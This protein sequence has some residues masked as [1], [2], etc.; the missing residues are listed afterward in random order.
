MRFFQISMPPTQ[1][2]FEVVAF[3]PFVPGVDEDD[4]FWEAIEGVAIGQ[5]GAEPF[6]VGLGSGTVQDRGAAVTTPGCVVPGRHDA[7]ETRVVDRGASKHGRH[8]FG[9]GE[10]T[11]VEEG[12]MLSQANLVEQFP[13]ARWLPRRGQRTPIGLEV[14]R[15]VV[16]IEL[17]AP[18]ALSGEA[19]H[20]HQIEAFEATE[21]GL[22]APEGGSGKGIR[23]CGGAVDQKQGF[24][25]DTD[26][27]RVVEKGQQ[28]L[29]VGEVVCL[30]VVLGDQH[31]LILAIPAACPVFIGPAEAEWKIWSA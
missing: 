8:Y 30:G 3:G 17:G 28:G 13:S 2:R 23:Q 26:V 14:E 29:D 6:A 24:V 10:H 19:L 4:G 5:N 22:L 27:A 21:L 16:A 7:G 15:G 18:L 1:I 9:I 12:M 20:L 11:V 25:P 31:L